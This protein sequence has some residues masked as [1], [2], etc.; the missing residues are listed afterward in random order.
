MLTTVHTTGRSRVRRFVYK[1]AVLFDEYTDKSSGIKGAGS[2]SEH[3]PAQPL[4]LCIEDTSATTVVS[5]LGLMPVQARGVLAQKRKERHTHINP[6]ARLLYTGSQ[7][8][9]VQIWRAPVVYR[10]CARRGRALP[11]K[12]SLLHQATCICPETVRHTPR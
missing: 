8:A 3:V 5:Q 10:H 12:H 1:Y 11:R 7:A 4:S 9:I 2:C 6:V